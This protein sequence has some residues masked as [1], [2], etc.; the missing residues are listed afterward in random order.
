MLKSLFPHIRFM[1]KV[2]AS[3]VVLIAIVIGGVA[4]LGLS[5]SSNGGT[6]EPVVKFSDFEGY[7]N[8]KIEVRSNKELKAQKENFHNEF[9]KNFQLILKNIS[10]YSK[11]TNQAEANSQSLEEHLFTIVSK[12]DYDLRSSY[13]TQLVKGTSNLVSYSEVVATDNTKSKIR[14]TDFLNWFTSDFDYQLNNSSTITEYVT[15]EST[16]F[17]N[18]TLGGMIIIVL[19]LGINMFILMGRD[20]KVDDMQAVATEVTT[21]DETAEVVTNTETT[22]VTTDTET[23]EVAKDTKA[24]ETVK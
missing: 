19:M 23:I 17:T 10:I 3:I 24:D 21:H 12:Y 15:I 14:W 13:L 4:Y 16:Q 8:S 2:V 9:F 1:G 7:V 20:K 11:A 22:E 5:N 18:A 6:G